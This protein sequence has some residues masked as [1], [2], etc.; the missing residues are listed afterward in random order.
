[1]KKGVFLLFAFV[2]SMQVVLAETRTES[3]ST[4]EHIKEGYMISGHVIE[5]DSE[6]SIPFATVL[7]V[8]TEKGTMSNEAGQFQF[9]GLSEGSYVLRVSAVGYKTME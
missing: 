9:K 2:M 7:I 1:M 4:I 3:P 8:G 6:E 5:K